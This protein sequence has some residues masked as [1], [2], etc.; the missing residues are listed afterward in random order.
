MFSPSTDFRQFLIS[1]TIEELLEWRSSGTG[2]E[3]R[4]YG[5]GNSL[6]WPRD[7]LYPQ[8]LATSP[9]SGGRSV[10][11]VRLRTTTTEFSFFLISSAQPIRWTATW[12]QLIGYVKCNPYPEPHAPWTLGTKPNQ[13]NEQPFIQSW[14]FLRRNAACEIRTV[15]TIFMHYNFCRGMQRMFQDRYRKRKRKTR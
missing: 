13:C 5:R 4:D 11:I 2:L 6:R 7:T 12:S 9:T 14:R 3:N 15:T 10:G 1:S 8:R